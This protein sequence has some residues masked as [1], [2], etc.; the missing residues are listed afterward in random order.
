[1]PKILYQILH[2][3]PWIAICHLSAKP[4]HFASRIG[5]T[6]RKW[7]KSLHKG[8]PNKKSTDDTL[9]CVTALHPPLQVHVGQKLDP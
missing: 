1:V 6:D 2:C 9:F 7:K 5:G 4:S 8:S 3:V